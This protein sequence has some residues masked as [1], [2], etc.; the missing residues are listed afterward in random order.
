MCFD[1][2]GVAVAIFIFLA[3]D[4]LTPG[5]HQR[6]TVTLYLTDISGSNHSLGELRISSLEPLAAIP[7]ASGVSLILMPEN[8]CGLV[9]DT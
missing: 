2:P 5:E 3:S 1:R 6:A 9:Y 8:V 7:I 4:G